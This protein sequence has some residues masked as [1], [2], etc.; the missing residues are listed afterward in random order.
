MRRQTKR[1]NCRGPEKRQLTRVGFIEHSAGA[2]RQ[3]IADSGRTKPQSNLRDKAVQMP[4]ADI[5][6]QHAKK[7]CRQTL[8]CGAPKRSETSICAALSDM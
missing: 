6:T 3:G 7:G 2:P 5:L 1:Q 8:F 4:K